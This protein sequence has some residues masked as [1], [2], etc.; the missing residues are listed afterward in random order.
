[1]GQM[2]DPSLVKR[3]LKDMAY[4]LRQ[5]AI[6]DGDLESWR[7]SRLIREVSTAEQVREAESRIRRL[8]RWT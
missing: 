4:R 2:Y 1:M 7:I 5:E 6:R 8:R 3:R